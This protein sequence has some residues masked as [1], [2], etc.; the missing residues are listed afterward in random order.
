MIVY[1]ADLHRR[2]FDPP[3]GGHHHER[4]AVAMH[5]ADARFLLDDED[6]TLATPHAHVRWWTTVAPLRKY[7]AVARSFADRL[8]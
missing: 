5:A 7:E 4:D 1:N 3:A 8:A 2:L 6:R